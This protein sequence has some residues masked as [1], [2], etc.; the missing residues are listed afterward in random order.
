MRD[1]SQSQ[2][3]KLKEIIGLRVKKIRRCPN[4]CV[5]KINYQSRVLCILF[6]IC[7]VFLAGVP[8][9]PWIPMNGFRN[10]D[11]YGF[12]RQHFTEV[13]FIMERWRTN[14]SRIRTKMVLYSNT[15]EKRVKIEEWLFRHRYIHKVIW[16]S[17]K[18]NTENQMETYWWVCTR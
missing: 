2:K 5:K 8:K 1:L 4:G 10:S 18:G 13:H 17:P 11:I 9:I 14:H 3:V 16:R 15:N 12:N 7:V 6:I